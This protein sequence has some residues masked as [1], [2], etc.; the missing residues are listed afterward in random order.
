MLV[1]GHERAW[2]NQL[3]KVRCGAAV[4]AATRAP[5][6][7][8]KTR[9]RQSF[10][11]CSCAPCRSPPSH[12]GTEEQDRPTLQICASGMCARG[13]CWSGVVTCS[14]QDLGQCSPWTSSPSRRIP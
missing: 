12:R 5:S 3:G 10:D 14:V 4:T 8:R 9:E 2:H 11:R 7:W 6:P 13:M 1:R